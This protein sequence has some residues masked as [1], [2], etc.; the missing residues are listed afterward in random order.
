[1]T[2]TEWLKGVHRLGRARYVCA[3]CGEDVSLELVFLSAVI[4]DDEMPPILPIP[5]IMKFDD[6]PTPLTDAFADS[7]AP[8]NSYELACRQWEIFSQNLE[9]KL[10]VAR[11]ALEWANQELGKCTKP[12]PVT[13]ALAFTVTKP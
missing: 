4:P 3:H 2:C 7:P 9:R 8:N 12:N 13:K 10:H 11:E 6:I 1:M 5:K